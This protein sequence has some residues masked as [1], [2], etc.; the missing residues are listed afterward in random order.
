MLRQIDFANHRLEVL[1]AEGLQD[2]RGVHWSRTRMGP[3]GELQH[4]LSMVR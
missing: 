3:S 1:T 2:V 4:V